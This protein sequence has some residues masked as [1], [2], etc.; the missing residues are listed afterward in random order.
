M[1]EDD[2]LGGSDNSGYAI[3]PRKAE[4]IADELDILLEQG[5]VKRYMKEYMDHVEGLDKEDFNSNY[6][7]DEENVRRF[8]RFCRESGGF[9]IC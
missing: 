4:E 1:T 2:F 6:P 3:S 7:F 5:E 9:E 8:S